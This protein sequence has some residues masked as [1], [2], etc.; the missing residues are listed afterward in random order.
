MTLPKIHNFPDDLPSE[1]RRR[2]LK[3]M[4]IGAAAGIFFPGCDA[5]RKDINSKGALARA[6]SSLDEMELGDES[7]WNTVKE[8]F[9]L[10]DGLIMLNAAN[11]CPSPISVQRRVFDLTSDVDADP[12]F[13]NREKFTSLKEG[14]R[15]A[16]A[17]FLGVSSD[18]I[19]I[20]RNTSEG[21]NVVISG[22]NLGPGDEVVIWDQN[23]PTAN[24][25]WDVRANRYGY[26]VKRVSTPENPQSPEDLLKVFTDAIT[27]KTKVLCFSHVSNV[28]GIRL[29][30]KELC[31]AARSAGILTLVDGAQTFGT[32]FLRLQEMGCDFFTGSSH[33]W[34]CGPKEV[35]ILYVRKERCM[36]LHPLLVGVG[37]ETS[38][39]A[40]ARRF[41]TLG[42]QDDSRIAAMKE[43][44]DFHN[45]IGLLRISSQ[46]RKLAD[47]VKAGLK[48]AVPGVKFITP[49][50]HPMSWGVVV[51]NIPGLNMKGALNTLYAKHSVGCAVMGE[52]IRFSPHIYNTHEDIEKAVTAI[53][54]LL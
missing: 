31:A 42:Q 18:E 9:P 43:A 48:K 8:Q 33:K 53:K 49:I 28:S 13:A 36:D 10:K 41:E 17:E 26:S 7:F 39:S 1:S 22:L 47:A 3:G 6:V 25:A 45:L 11:L 24:I 19:A 5:G 23:H 29:P 16:L 37:W 38:G 27:S 54:Q 20:V 32:Y 40:G 52:N 14:S 15:A 21:N 12:S 46:A 44:V 50:P 34:F 35:G 2:L 30:A 4:L 51:F